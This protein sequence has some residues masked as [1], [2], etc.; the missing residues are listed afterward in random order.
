MLLLFGRKS[1]G[2]Y[3]SCDEMTLSI[4]SRAKLSP[5]RDQSNETGDA[6]FTSRFPSLPQQEASLTFIVAFVHHPLA[7]AETLTHCGLASAICKN[8]VEL[9]SAGCGCFPAPSPC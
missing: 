1:R 5:I 6:S 3:Q 4:K 8:G 2:G 7:L 9:G